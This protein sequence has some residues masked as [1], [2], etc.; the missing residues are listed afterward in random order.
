MSGFICIECGQL[1][2]NPK[3]YVERHGLD[4]GSFEEWD[5]CPCC[6]GNYAEAYQCDECRE[7]IR[8]TYVKTTGG[9]RICEKC[10]IVMEIGDE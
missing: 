2:D 4:I 10:Y 9:Q 8:G 7:W 6:G 5:G 3:H 1:F